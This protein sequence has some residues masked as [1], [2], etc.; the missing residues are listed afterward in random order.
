MKYIKLE[1]NVPIHYTIEQLFKDFPTAVIYKVSQ[2]PDEQLLAGYNV[3]PLIT[4]NMPTGDVV[5]EGI[6]V[7]INNEWH[8]TWTTRSFTTEESLLKQTELKE[9]ESKWFVDSAVSKKR[10]D[11]CQLCENFNNLTTQCKEC[12]CIMILKT[13]IQSATCPI[14]KW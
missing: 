12:N 9:Q 1:N 7:L 2:M 4:T 13:K 14:N 8:Q 6:P 10:Y 11:I 5:V 3:Y